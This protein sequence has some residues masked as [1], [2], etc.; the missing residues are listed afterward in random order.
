MRSTIT[1]LALAH[2]SVK[3]NTDDVSPMKVIFL[4]CVLYSKSN[5]VLYWSLVD[6]IVNPH[7]L[8]CGS[9]GWSRLFSSISHKFPLPLQDSKPGFFSL[10]PLCTV[11]FKY[12]N[13]QLPLSSL[14]CCSSNWVHVVTSPLQCVLD[15]TLTN[16]YLFMWLPGHH[17]KYLRFIATTSVARRLPLRPY[18]IDVLYHLNIKIRNHFSCSEICGTGF[19]LTV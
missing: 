17:N 6:Y 13:C 8:K 7:R 19:P 10:C 14:N 4:L 11:D 9:S 1:P 3:T 16:Q 18:G 15:C 12:S 2:S 5:R